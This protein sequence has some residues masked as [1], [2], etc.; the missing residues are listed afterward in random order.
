MRFGKRKKWLIAITTILILLI[1][2][3][4]IWVNALI[5]PVVESQISQLVQEKSQGLYR[6][7][8]FSLSWNVANQSFTLTDI[9]LHYDS[10]E[11]EKL[12]LTDHPPLNV[13]QFIAPV[14]QMSFWDFIH[15]FTD[16]NF[17][18]RKIAIEKPRI[19][20]QRLRESAPEDSLPNQ[21]EVIASL[22][23]IFNSLQVNEFTL[24]EGDF[25]Y[26]FGSQGF[27]AKNIHVS[28]SDLTLD[29]LYRS[30][31][32]EW[33][34]VGEVNM[35]MDLNDYSFVLPDSSYVI[36]T[37]RVGISSARSEIY[38]DDFR[39]HPNYRTYQLKQE[40]GIAQTNLFEVTIPRIQIGGIGIQKAW[41][42]NKLDIGSVRFINPHF[43]QL[44]QVEEDSLKK[45][46]HLLT[47]AALYQKISP[48]FSA[49]GIG[50]VSIEQAS[51]ERLTQLGDTTRRASID[52]VG[53]YLQNL[54]LDSLT[55]KEEPRL[56]LSDEIELKVDTF[57]IWL[58]KNNYLLTGGRTEI[59]TFK[60]RLLFNDIRISP[61]ARKWEEAK[62]TG[63]DVMELFVPSMNIEGI[64]A[65]QAWYEEILD[66]STIQISRPRFALTN[67]P[68]IQKQKVD[69][70]ARADL[71]LLIDDYLKS[72]TVRRLNV[73]EG[74]FLFNPENEANTLGYQASDLNIRIA[75]FKLN[76]QARRR[77][78]NPFYADD[79]DI[80]LSIQDYSWMLP[81][82]SHA[83]AIN[84][85]GISTADSAIFLDSV[86]L[87]PQAFPKYDGQNNHRAA[88]LVPA[89]RLTGLDA[90]QAYFNKSLRFD[91]L[92]I[93]QP[94]L[95]LESRLATQRSAEASPWNQFDLYPLIKDQL[96]AIAINHIKLKNARLEQKMIKRDTV[97]SLS[98]PQL[99]MAISDFFIDDSTRM[100]SSNML[101]AQDIQLEA[102]GI[103]HA[104]KDSVHAL[105]L[106]KLLLSTASGKVEMNQ[107]NIFPRDSSQ[108]QKERKTN[109][110]W[111]NIPGLKLQGL[112]LF[113][114]YQE[115]ICAVERLS[116]QQPKLVME[117]Y[118]NIEKTEIDS[119]AQADLYHSISN[120]L[121][122]LLV[123]EF[124]IENGGISFNQGNQFYPRAFSAN[125]IQLKIKGFQLDSLARIKSNNPFYAENLEASA[126]IE[127]YQFLVPDST[128]EVKVGSIGFETADSSLFIDDISVRPQLDHPKFS[129]AHSALMVTI[130]RLKITG[131]NTQEIYFDEKIDLDRI[132]LP[133]PEVRLIQL[134]NE[135]L[136]DHPRPDPFQR[137]YDHLAPLNA[138]EILLENAIFIRDKYPG[139]ST[140]TLSIDDVSLQ[141]RGFDL[142]SLGPLRSERLY[143]SDEVNLTIRNHEIIGKDSLYRWNFGEIGLFSAEKSARLKGV[144]LTPTLDI[145]DYVI[146]YGHTTNH[147]EALA[148]QV[149]ITQLDIFRLLDK[150]ELFAKRADIQGL[151]L[152]IKKDSQFSRDTSR[153]PLFPQEFLSQLE[154]VLNLDSLT[155][156][157]GF[158]YFQNK[159]EALETPAIFRLSNVEAQLANI[160]NAPSVLA[161]NPEKEMVMKAQATMMDSGQL[162]A[163][164]HFPL[165]D[166]DQS[167]RI[168]GEMQGWN[169]AE[170]NPMLVPSASIRVNKGEMEEVR[171]WVEGN[172]EISK[173]KMWMHYHDLN[174]SVIGQKD[175]NKG[176]EEKVIRRR[177]VA[178]T[179]ANK[180]VVKSDNPNRRF[181]RVGKISYEVDPSRG[182][183]HHW[184]QSVLSGVKSSIGL[185]DEEE[186][187]KKQGWRRLRKSGQ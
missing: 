73:N 111:L 122:A 45:N 132:Y 86:Q 54:K 157:K 80:E 133:K 174:V 11:L 146:K 89:M 61:V 140:S 129:H 35:E 63:A 31:L 72:L 100:G 96:S 79:I 179:I 24:S 114:L 98:L 56:F 110:Y 167:Y 121:K 18:A 160:T 151:E 44:S 115:K 165:L 149:N 87:I 117:N 13:F 78:D 64:D 12:S 106:G 92:I 128:Y 62:R 88:L 119:I 43:Y 126:R 39:L 81:D 95:L 6:L 99:S 68:K 139:D 32:A 52:G 30:N 40:A 145:Y 27:S 33:I 124:Q 113:K 1:V 166:K 8:P 108:A 116:V 49:V 136:V 127:N 169:L 170:L 10:L 91:S 55:I 75:N 84:H 138:R 177:P 36:Q 137:L 141:L 168:E 17:N 131:W 183:V 159:K 130:P 107:I 176:E 153:R 65:V 25:Q 94:D 161:R 23:N 143:Y 180:L 120:Q 118:P 71:Y 155:I 77:Q 48:L 148:N 58:S 41:L 19:K 37:Q 57:N 2:S 69:S 85:I 7:D 125:D 90:Y 181:L 156:K 76:P 15:A 178:S 152:M 102:E 144:S 4:Q 142:D 97:S 175:G 187:D 158:L 172:K 5:V 60:K 162:S 53:L 14:I 34:T 26:K 21:Q 67:Y 59:S 3:V 29:S 182:F 46:R 134:G 112:D 164:F 20:V 147:V 38:I 163:L 103:Q 70:L 42:E 123:N 74:Q 173:G 135:A 82:S 171:F 186:K 51:Y 28:V 47:P 16:K 184:V 50:G 66:V 109:L 150:E 185:D 101:Y 22:S 104:L 154:L 83:L 9:H 93:S 105:S